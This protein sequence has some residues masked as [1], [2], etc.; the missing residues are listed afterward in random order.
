MLTVIASAGSEVALHQRVQRRATGRNF[1]QGSTGQGYCAKL[2]YLVSIL[3]NGVVPPDAPEG[4]RHEV[5]PLVQRL[6]QRH[7]IGV[8]RAEFPA[9]V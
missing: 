2:Q 9:D 8:L 6:L 7:N 3:V 1:R 4:F 5:G